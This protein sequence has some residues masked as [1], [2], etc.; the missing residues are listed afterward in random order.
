MFSAHRLVFVE[1]FVVVAAPLLMAGTANQAVRFSAIF[2]VAAYCLVGLWRAGAIRDYLRPNWRGFVA[3]LPGVLLRSA[4]AALAIASL[5]LVLHPNRLFCI[6]R[7]NPDLMLIIAC[8]YAF[9]S[10]LPQ[11]IAFR[12]YAAFRLDG[13]K[14]SPLP[15]TLLSAAV[16]GWVHILYG[17]WISVALTFIAGIAFYRTYRGSSSILAAWLEHSLYGLAV[18]AIG[19]DH[20][21]YSGPGTARLEAAC[22]AAPLWP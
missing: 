21:F 16:F 6:P 17:S 8:F 22:M 2:L 9:V 13:L 10:V 11:E 20:L 3:A 12:A 1:L 4:I 18:F 7:A 19:L 14:V 5:V 15:A